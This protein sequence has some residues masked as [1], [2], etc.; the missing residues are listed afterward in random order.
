MSSVENRT[1][2]LRT[3]EDY[4]QLFHSMSNIEKR[5]ALLS[6]LRGYMLSDAPQWA[7]AQDLAARKNGWFASQSITLAV[8]NIAREFLDEER[9]R[10]WI[11]RYS[12]PEI[13]RTVGIVM[14]G[15]IPLV[16]FHDFLCGFVAGHSLQIKLSTKDDVLLPHLVQW[17]CSQD[18]AELARISFVERLQ[19]CEAFI[20]TGSNNSARYFEQY[21][22]HKPH[23]IRKG[24]TSV[25]VLEGSETD[26]ELSALSHDV[27]DFFGLGCRNITQLYVPKD[28]DFGRFL[29]QV[30]GENHITN[31]HKFRNNYDYHLALYLL[32]RVPYFSS[33]NLLLVENE[34][35]FSAVATLHYQFYTDREALLQKLRADNRI[36]A[37][38]G[39][40]GIPFGEAQRPALAD[41]ADGVDTMAFL[42][43]L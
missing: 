25:A 12:L 15:N 26:E 33:E 35:P 39:K 13:A 41:Y 4:I 31:H 28:Y 18:E 9:L 2:L 17:L 6:K 10:A 27:F 7:E 24:R 38:V 30:Q 40:G 14:A 8:E 16:G 22:G 29:A 32:N 37:I 34:I 43:G 1:A 23:L 21:F 11:S 20:A 36:Q 5:I 3:L 42:C 19:A